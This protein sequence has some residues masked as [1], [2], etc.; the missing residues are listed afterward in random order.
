M[1]RFARCTVEAGQ[2]NLATWVKFDPVISFAD[3]Q[4]YPTLV[5]YLNAEW[6]T[7]QAIPHPMYN[8]F[9]A[10][11]DTFDVGVLVL[12]RSV[13][14]S[15]YGALPPLGFLDLL[16]T[17]QNRKDG[18]FTVVGYGSQGVLKPFAQ[19]DFERYVG[20]ASLIEVNSASNGDQGAKF[21]NNPGAGKGPG[22]TCFGDSGG[23]VFWGTSNVI[24]ATVSWGITPCVGVDYQFRL[25]T[26]TAQ[27]FI[28]TYLP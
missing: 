22:G 17:G 2:V 9:A 8:D 21:T 27:D 19:D 11:P 26:A 13:A 15:S 20:T 23:P 10:F 12:S 14:L 28:K 7:A 25:D 4:N 18:L 1:K 16:S 24:G 6:I 5:D 3:R